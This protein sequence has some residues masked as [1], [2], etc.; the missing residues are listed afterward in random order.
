MGR[1]RRLEIFPHLARSTRPSGVRNDNTPRAETRAADGNTEHFDEGTEFAHQ[2]EICKSARRNI[3]D[4]YTSVNLF[5]TRPALR[6]SRGASYEM[7]LGTSSE[8]CCCRFLVIDSPRSS[9]SSRDPPRYPLLSPRRF[10]SS[11]HGFPAERG[12]A[13]Y[14]TVIP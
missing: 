2:R 12:I 8:G 5:P 11:S 13:E 10:L 1:K 3:V 9:S 4:S 6:E 7:G 14:L